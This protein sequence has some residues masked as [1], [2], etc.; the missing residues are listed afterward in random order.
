MGSAVA[1]PG[2]AEAPTPEKL[3]F[4]VEHTQI[5]EEWI[6][7]LDG[8]LPKLTKFILP[9]GG[10][11][12]AN[13][14]VARSVCRRAERRVVVLEVKPSSVLCYLNRLSDFL[15]VAARYAAMKEGREEITYKK[16]EGKKVLTKKSK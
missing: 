10:L 2:T 7:F 3:A 13:L 11:S 6:D 1:T 15:F 12:S 5:L 4:G 9:S 8:Q 16:S 14:H